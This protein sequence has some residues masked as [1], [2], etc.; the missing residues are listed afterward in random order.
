MSALEWPCG[1]E[2]IPKPPGVWRTTWGRGHTAPQHPG[3]P[4]A[5]AF[6]LLLASL[7][8]PSHTIPRA[9]C[10]WA[11]AG[12]G[13]NLGH[14][15]LGL[16]QPSLGWGQER[17]WS[18]PACG[19]TL[20]QEAHT[21]TLLG[22]VSVSPARHDAPRCF[23]PELSGLSEHICTRLK[24]VVCVSDIPGTFS[25]QPPTLRAAP[26]HAVTSLGPDWPST[27]SADPWGLRDPLGS[28]GPLQG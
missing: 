16:G 19:P 5:L 20:T 2:W 6:L 17:A 10:W 8:R 24:R 18:L 26:A 4:L 15:G 25:K 21:E 11:S 7:L 9:E 12:C 13:R 22:T 27:A 3:R 28:K 14:I 1:S 23:L